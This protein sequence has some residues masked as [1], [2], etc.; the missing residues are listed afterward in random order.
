[1]AELPYKIRKDLALKY[2]GRT[3]Y[4]IEA[5][6]DIPKHRVCKGALGGYVESYDNLQDNAWIFKDAKVCDKAKV[7]D[8]ARIFDSAV[9]G[10]HSVV[11]GDAEVSGCA[12]VNDYA[13]VGDYAYVTDNARILGNAKVYGNAEVWGDACIISKSDYIV[14]KNWW[15]SGR[16]FTW[17]RSNNM[18]KVGC[19]HGTGEEL[20]AKA[21]DDSK[22]SGDNY[23]AIVDYV[24]NVVIPQQN[25]KSDKGADLFDVYAM[26]YNCSR[27]EAKS[28]V[29]AEVAKYSK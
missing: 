19:F 7:Y 6:V 8:T 21:Y 24:N 10:G 2:N 20:I 27:E 13:E 15:S 18:W 4:R 22:V 29:F 11:R 17:T 28:R 16:Y 26:Y 1:M 9:V 3:L 12:F 5:L 23:K 14:F 25:Q